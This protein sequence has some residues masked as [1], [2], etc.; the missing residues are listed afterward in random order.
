M[1]I[2]GRPNVGKSTLFNRIVGSQQAIV[3]DRPGITRDRKELE[4]EWLD[5]PFLVVDTGGW[6]PG[7]DELESKVSRQVEAAVREADVVLFVVDA[8]VG[9]TDD[10][11]T[12]ANW[13]RRSGTQVIVVANKADNE[14]RETEMWEFMSLGIG[15]PVPVSALHG[16]R[17][18]DLLDAVLERFP[19][20]L[21]VPAS[22]PIDPWA[23]GNDDDDRADEV[24]VPRVAIVGR[25][26]VG[27]STLF[28]RLVGEDRAVVH[29]LAGTTRDSIDTLVDTD[30]GPIVFID[31]A[32]MR[33][34]GKI[35]DSAEYYSFV[36]AL[37][38]IDDA[39]VALL[40]IDATVGVT[41]Q[42]QRLAERVDSAGCPIVLI[43]NKWD[44][45]GHR[46]TPAG[47]GR[48]EA[49]A[50]VRRRLV[51]A[52][53]L[54]AE[55]QERRETAPATPRGDLAVPHAG[56]DQGR[57]QG[58]RRRAAAPAGRW[59]R[60]DH[61]RR[62][63]CDRSADVHVVR[64]PGDPTAL[65]ALHRAHDPRG[66]RPRFDRAQ[67]PGPQAPVSPTITRRA[68]TR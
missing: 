25:P 43:L 11:Q 35:D 38:S 67:A 8:S 53:D 1:V 29:D 15:E 26:N 62:A 60:E 48:G 13:I 12:I 52:E 44:L 34:K 66:V 55:R 6:M 31:T 49:H 20:H 18:G 33:R 36:R 47:A 7:G 56:A 45:V 37:R 5:I 50:G 2:I 21:R 61:V 57:Q 28:N 41:A 27:K 24:S 23:P 68:R 46:G 54:G 65:P 59:R 3:E 51:G 22:K 58:D 4:A 39:D 63:G 30:G 19:E 9:L 14:R 17:A 10:D 40:V 16:R 64:Q 32:G 42:D